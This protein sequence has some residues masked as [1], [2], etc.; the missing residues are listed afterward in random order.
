MVQT[1]SDACLQAVLARST[2]N[3]RCGGRGELLQQCKECNTCQEGVDKCTYGG[4]T[5]GDVSTCPT[6]QSLATTLKRRLT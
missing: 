5:R 4:L 3:A 2:C 6:A 1:V